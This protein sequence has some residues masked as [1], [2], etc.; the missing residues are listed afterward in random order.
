MDGADQQ[1]AYDGNATSRMWRGLEVGDTSEVCAAL[2]TDADPN[3]LDQER[4]PLSMLSTFPVEQD[5]DRAA[6]ALVLS[7]SD[8]QE[9]LGEISLRVQRALHA[10]AMDCG[11]EPSRVQMGM[12][13]LPSAFY[14]AY[15][16]AV[17]DAGETVW[18]RRTPSNRWGP[19][20][21]PT[22]LMWMAIDEGDVEELAIAIEEGANPRRRRADGKLPIQ[23]L[24]AFCSADAGVAA[25][26]LVMNSAT[27]EEQDD[28]AVLAHLQ[29]GLIVCGLHCGCS[30]EDAEVGMH[31]LP[32]QL[33]PLYLETVQRFNASHEKLF[34]R[35]ATDAAA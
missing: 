17:E 11:T 26:L 21:G 24:G 33:Y 25:L 19:M 13:M 31:H 9:W 27:F 12:H 1:H 6:L 34:G 23:S 10:V 15:L 28:P 8:W 18:R 32:P 16:A 20:S 35:T 30:N 7:G 22:R 29:T 4:H 5:A 2:V 14:P 3:A